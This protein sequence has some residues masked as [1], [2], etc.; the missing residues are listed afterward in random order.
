[1]LHI[2]LSDLAGS[3]YTKRIIWLANSRIRQIGHRSDHG[4]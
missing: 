2:T 3:S 1:M 4:L